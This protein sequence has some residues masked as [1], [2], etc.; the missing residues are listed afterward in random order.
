MSLKLRYLSLNSFDIET[1]GGQKIVIDPT[2]CRDYK[3]TPIK[4]EDYPAPDYIFLSHGHPNDH[5]FEVPY[6]LSRYDPIVI[7]TEPVVD[8]LL[9]LGKRYNIRPDRLMPVTWDSTIFLGNGESMYITKA[10]HYPAWNFVHLVLGRDVE[11]EELRALGGGLKAADEILKRELPERTQ[12]LDE[13]KE[14][15]GTS[16][17]PKGSCIGFHLTNKDGTTLWYSG[18]CIAHAD[19]KQYALKC[20]PQIALVQTVLGQEEEA[21]KIISWLQ[22][23]IA[24]PF[25]HEKNFDRQPGPEADLGYFKKRVKELSKGARVMVPEIGK[26]VE[27]NLTWK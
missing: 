26:W 12:N 22:P 23:S 8:F 13:V 6:L 15:F 16:D 18:S 3:K 5:L 9:T 1:E 14:I 2:F 27:F 17:V 4:R 19:L 11:P 10:I 24:V 21:A 20:R 7:T 25:H